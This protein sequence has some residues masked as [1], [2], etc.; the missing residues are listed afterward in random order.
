M[1]SKS[2]LELFST[3]KTGDELYSFESLTSSDNETS[4][5]SDDDDGEL[6]I[7]KK[8][9]NPEKD[10]LSNRIININ[11]LWKAIKDNTICKKYST[12]KEV[13]IMQN[14]VDK[15]SKKLKAIMNI[16]IPDDIILDFLK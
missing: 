11:H 7:R 6:T 9:T 4:D 13:D 1:E 10:T 2:I 8:A 15:F 16:N 3:K 12:K 14:V 5:G